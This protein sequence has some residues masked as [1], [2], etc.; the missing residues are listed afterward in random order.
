MKKIVNLPKE[1]IDY[2]YKISLPYC[3]PRTKRGN[4]T[5]GLILIIE[6]YR[7]WEKESPQ[8]K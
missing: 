1:L 5:K 2:V 3:D 7:E 4:F 6:K 8:K